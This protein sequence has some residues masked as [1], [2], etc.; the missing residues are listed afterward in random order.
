MTRRS[1]LVR[2]DLV[3]DGTFESST[4]CSFLCRSRNSQASSRRLLSLIAVLR[5][6][7]LSLVVTGLAATVVWSST[8]P[9]M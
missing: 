6:D 5:R 4:A 3:K 9:M 7:D 2:R 8:E 1:I